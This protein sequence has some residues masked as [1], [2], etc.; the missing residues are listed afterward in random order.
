MWYTYISL[1]MSLYMFTM[2]DIAN[3]A[4][5]AYDKNEWIKLQDL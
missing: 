3:A 2:N 4:I 1:I 5:S